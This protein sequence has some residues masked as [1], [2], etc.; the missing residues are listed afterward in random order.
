MLP[1][2]IEC[3]RICVFVK[4][5]HAKPSIFFKTLRSSNQMA[6]AMKG[7][8]KVGETMLIKQ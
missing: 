1:S 4:I 8:A 2:L 3:Y 5:S 6:Q 7:V